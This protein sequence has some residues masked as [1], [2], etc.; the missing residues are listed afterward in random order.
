VEKER[1]CGKEILPFPTWEKRNRVSQRKKKRTSKKDCAKGENASRTSGGEVI[2]MF[3]PSGARAGIDQRGVE[4]NQP[5]GTKKR[6]EAAEAREKLIPK[7]AKFKK[8]AGKGPK[9][10]RSG[11]RGEGLCGK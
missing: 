1:V 4:K 5:L 6:R 11:K 3:R 7:P 9:G 2:R 10:K 8:E